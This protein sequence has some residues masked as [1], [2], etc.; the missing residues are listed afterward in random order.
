M[1]CNIWYNDICFHLSILGIDTPQPHKQTSQNKSLRDVKGNWNY[2]SPKELPNAKG[3]D[4]DW[5]RILKTILEFKKKCSR[6][7]VKLGVFNHFLSIFRP[8]QMASPPTPKWQAYGVSSAT[9]PTIHQNGSNDTEFQGAKGG[10]FPSFARTS[11]ERIEM[12]IFLRRLW[13][14]KKLVFATSRQWIQVSGWYPHESWYLRSDDITYQ[15][16]VVEMKR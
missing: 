10:S 12:A 16:T 6:N 4:W 13:G 2:K 1:I 15:N 14:W 8:P 5:I 3:F 11:R 7:L 9:I